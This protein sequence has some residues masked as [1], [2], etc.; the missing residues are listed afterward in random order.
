MA[1]SRICSI[2]N[3]GKSFKAKG[4]CSMHYQRL[5]KYG[6]PLEAKQD[7]ATRGDP[8]RFIYDVALKYDG[9]DCLKWPY[10]DNGKGYGIVRVDGKNIG[11][12]RYICELVKGKPPTPEHDA[13]HECNNGHLGCVNPSHLEW[14][15]RA[16]NMADKFHNGTHNRGQNHNLAKITEA[17]VREIRR[18]S[19]SLS[20]REIGRRFG[21]TQQQVSRITSGARWSCLE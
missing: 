8:L 17:D 13:A 9:T 4:C 5:L 2:P 3:C 21:I 1:N 16:G 12:H 7:Y 14:K 15:T 10:A 6:D 20:Q 11:A 19:G 18:L